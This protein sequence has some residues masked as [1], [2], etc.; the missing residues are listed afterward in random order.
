[1]WGKWHIISPLSEKVGGTRPRVPHPN[2]AHGP[3][4]SV[5]VMIKSRPVTSLGHQ[6][7]RVFWEGPKVLNYVQ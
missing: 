3:D 4:R 5:C 2:C 7:G 1:M 6:K